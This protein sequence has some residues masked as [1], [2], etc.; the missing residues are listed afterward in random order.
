MMKY[1]TVIFVWLLSSEL[2][3]N[4]QW[5]Q[6]SFSAQFGTEVQ[7]VLNGTVTYEIMDKQSFTFN[8]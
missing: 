4:F 5:I 1:I 7:N 3:S 2:I 6:A 8:L